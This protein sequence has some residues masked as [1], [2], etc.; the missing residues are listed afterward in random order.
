MVKC[1]ISLKYTVQKSEGCFSFPCVLHFLTI[2][3]FLMYSYSVFMKEH[4]GAICSN[5]YMYAYYVSRLYRNPR[6]QFFRVTFGVSPRLFFD[7]FSAAF[8]AWN[9]SPSIPWGC[10][11]SWRQWAPRTWPVM[12][13]GITSSD[14]LR[15]IRFLALTEW[16]RHKNACYK[17]PCLSLESFRAVNA[18]CRPRRSVCR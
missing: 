4:R 13:T 9:L 16:I 18:I 17:L 8:H 11:V 10:G 1:F 7:I 3:C 5:L 6:T 2:L 12:L 14:N 15:E